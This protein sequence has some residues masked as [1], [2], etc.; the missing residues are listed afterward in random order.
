ML[1]LR[2][3]PLLEERNDVGLC[4]IFFPSAWLR[5]TFSFRTFIDQLQSALLASGSC[6][7][8][9]LPPLQAEEDFVHG[10][11]QWAGKTLGLYFE[12][13]LGYLQLEAPS[14]EV[15]QEISSF[16][17]SHVQVVEPPPTPKSL[18]R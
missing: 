1:Q 10:K 7:T 3:P 8:V 16:V 13:A 9:E 17:A 18:R 4:L 12:Y 14:R 15:L 2:M 5:R 6:L 11:A